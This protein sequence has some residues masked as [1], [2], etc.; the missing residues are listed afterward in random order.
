MRRVCSLA[1]PTT[2]KNA[3]LHTAQAALWLMKCVWAAKIYIYIYNI[4]HDH[5]QLYETSSNHFGWV[6]RSSFLLLWKFS[7]LIQTLHDKYIIYSS[8]EG[9]IYIYETLL[10]EMT[11]GL[12]FELDFTAK[13]DVK[14]I[15]FIF[16]N[17]HFSFKFLFFKFCNY[18]VSNK[19]FYLHK[20]S[21]S[22]YWNTN[23]TNSKLKMNIGN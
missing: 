7:N 13:V 4:S 18:F 14:I 12:C 23:M 2:L 6:E 16:W 1:P 15:K 19:L 9:N 17:F 21:S 3:N 10:L 20:I 11:T 8:I 5:H 22:P